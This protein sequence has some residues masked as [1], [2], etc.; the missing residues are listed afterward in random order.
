MCQPVVGVVRQVAGG[1]RTGLPG[2]QDDLANPKLLEHRLQWR[3]ASERLGLV[4][5]RFQK[6][7]LG[8]HKF[9]Q[10]VRS[11]ASPGKVAR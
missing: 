9:P 7:C 6:P 10:L 3:E 2:A 11:R 8:K 5:E 4:R 1:V